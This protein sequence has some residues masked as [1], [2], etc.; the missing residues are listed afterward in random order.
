V[1][2][3]VVPVE[4]GDWVFF[5]ELYAMANIDADILA[6]LGMHSGKLDKDISDHGLELVVEAVD[7]KEIW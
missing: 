6:P 4:H 5:P 7:K 1:D 3:V 2:V